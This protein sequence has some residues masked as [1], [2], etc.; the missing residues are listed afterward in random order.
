M[1]ILEIHALHCD[2]P[3]PNLPL[4]LLTHVRNTSTCASVLTRYIETD[5]TERKV[6]SGCYADQ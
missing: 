5:L 2:T 3:L 4:C 1:Q 6:L